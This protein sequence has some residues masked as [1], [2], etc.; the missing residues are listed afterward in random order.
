MVGVILCTHSVFADGLKEAIEMIAGKQDYFDSICFMNGDDPEELTERIKAAAQK[1]RDAKMPFFIAVD[2]Y[3]AT[4]FNAA[5]RMALE[6]NIL[7]MAGANMPFLL[8]V[9]TSRDSFEGGDLKTFLEDA[10]ESA[11]NNM[12]VIAPQE[13]LAE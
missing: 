9:L 11:R 12:Q 13:L 2:L 5:L 10:L 1:Y 3:A 8:E 7:M 6:D 4:P